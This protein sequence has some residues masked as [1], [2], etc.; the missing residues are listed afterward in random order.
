MI[1][2]FFLYSTAEPSCAVALMGES[3]NFIKKNCDYH[4][5]L[6]HLE[7]AVYR[8]G[9]NKLLLNNI[10]AISV[11]RKGY[12]H[13]TKYGDYASVTDIDQIINITKTQAIFDLP[14]E[15]VVCIHKQI[16]YSSKHCDAI[17]SLIIHCWMTLTV[18]LN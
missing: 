6:Q 17:I 15:S 14:C 1:L 16:F 8:I 10:S 3:L 12:D 5:M 9:A 18:Q 11:Y 4:I 7:P 2:P 13:S